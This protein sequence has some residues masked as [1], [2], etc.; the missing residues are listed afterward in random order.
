M[1]GY[2][3][4]V[5]VRRR[6]LSLFAAMLCVASQAARLTAQ[7]PAAGGIVAGVTVDSIRG[8]LLPGTVVTIQGTALGAVSDSSGRFRI[9]GIP[10]GRYRVEFR[11][12]FTDT[13]RIALRTTVRESSGADSAFLVLS[14][15]SPRSLI[16]LKCGEAERQ[17]GAGMLLGIVSEA[18]TGEPAAG[19]EVSMEWTDYDLIGKSL[20]IVPQKR[21]AIVGPDGDYRMCGIPADLEAGVV[22]TRAGDTTAA[23]PAD[24]R[25][26][27]VLAS[28][29][30]S[31]AVTNSVHGEASTTATGR[32][33]GRVVDSAGR[34]VEGARVSA[35]HDSAFAITDADGQFG[36]G[37]LRPGT[38]AILVRRLGFHP[39]TQPVSVHADAAVSVRVALT[40]YVPVLEA[41]MIT[42]RRNF[43]LERVGFT[44]RQR[45]GMGRYLTPDQIERRKP[46][47]LTDILT[48]VPS[49]RMSRTARGDPQVT[50]RWGE[51][52]R[53]FVDGHRWSD[54]G[55]GPDGFISGDEIGAVEVY[56]GFSA[57]GEYTSF[58]GNG[59]TC[60][61]V[62]VWTKGK[63]GI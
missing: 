56:S 8:R 40:R 31:P 24:F 30:V 47:R 18:I 9:G 1:A 37:G 43:E 57:P 16:A 59:R 63:L 23:L 5:M 33:T 4:N 55:E 3:I 51:C 62:V 44:R 54:F 20:T 60:T 38:R 15:P 58:G 39:V 28:F 29:Q 2:L 52:I 21:S 19:A 49:L 27:V 6:P 14:V 42:A 11:H 17:Q 34:A 13:L 48:M 10:A 45:S 32:V 26:G 7:Q 12:P 41:V 46:Q 25:T 35:G 36:I 50:G 53:Y 61:S 22:A